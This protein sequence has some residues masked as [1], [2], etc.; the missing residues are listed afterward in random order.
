MT[1][2]PTQDLRVEEEIERARHD[3][4]YAD[5]RTE[6]VTPLKPV[7]WQRF[8]TGKPSRNAYISSVQRLG[9][10]SGKTVL[11]VGCGTG[12]FSVILAKRGAAQVDGFDISGEA[13][14]DAEI[15]ADVNDCADVC[16]FRRGS[17]YEIPFDD[18]AYDVVAGQAIIHHLRN[19]EVTA[20]E[21]HRVMKPGAKA[22]FYEP[23]GNSEMFERFRQKLPIASD[24]DDPDHWMDKVSLK[25]LD[26]FREYFDVK[27]QEFE[28]LRA[29]SRYIPFLSGTLEVTDDL[30]IKAIPG[31]RWFARGIVFELHKAAE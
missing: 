17:C 1:D 12:W 25:Q 24:T 14:K 13:V 30:L 4:M 29:L 22:V 21:L 5:E 9:D 10:L 2:D 15:C 3:E 27:W 6:G 19:K 7:D 20:R 28:L 23:L 26:P 11:D 18:E 8:D 16:R 31:V